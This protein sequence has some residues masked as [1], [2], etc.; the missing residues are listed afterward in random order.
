MDNST[1]PRVAILGFM[2]ES[3]SF[4]PVATE[5]DFR[6][7]CYLE[8]EVIVEEARKA[9]S[10]VH[11]ETSGFV[12][13]MDATGPWDPYPIIVTDC[14]PAGPVDHAFFERTLGAMV[15]RLEEGGPIDA[16]FI[17]NH[18]AM[19][20][21]EITDPDGEMFKRIR[22]VV[23]DNCPI[24]V[25]LDLHANISERMV[26][27]SDVIIGYLTNPHVD[28]YERGEEA[29]LCMRTL[30]YGT[31][32]CQVLV[33]LPLTPPSVT[34][35]S[36]QGPY[37][38]LI[39]FGQ[40]RRREYAG[41]VLNLSVFGGFVFSDTPEN[42]IAV[43]VS[44]RDELSPAIALANEIA[45]R[46]WKNRTQFEKTLTSLSDAVLL[47]SE[48]DD[49]SAAIIFSD[50]GDNPGGGGG[51]NTT[52]LLDALVQAEIGGVLY[53]SFFDPHLAAQAHLLG[54]GCRFEAVFNREGETEFAKRLS[55]PASVL[56]L[57]DGQIVGR[58]G[59]YEN[60][61]V[62]LGPCC[63][64]GIGENNQIVVIVIS[65]R[66]Q[67]AD[68]MFFEQFGIDVGHFRVV[69]VKSRGHFR[70]GF[71]EWFSPEQVYE[72]DTIGLTS[73]VLNRFQW[74]GLPRPVYPLD[75]NVSW[76]PTLDS[77]HHSSQSN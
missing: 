77:E 38:D 56:G 52:W 32:A 25:T 10:N 20:S 11:M 42:G 3:N 31:K 29:A 8:G 74:R 15:E 1:P 27:Q 51:G 44:G 30:L 14:E 70:A 24:V 2:L 61:K 26:R 7:R 68:P 65:N 50:A 41:K 36:A 67:T 39:E 37:A 43:V 23:G 53:G 28:M 54:N 57:S 60:R 62:D 49:S 63:A 12:R 4:A 45:E 13:T 21:T 18:G 34:L 5:A 59:I 75:Q 17:A 35:L 19:V 6:S 72:I 40:R 33:R 22:Q 55:V 64:L 48:R 47:A 71:D 73:P 66:Q 69:C 76:L 9:V 58:R 16:V 46:G